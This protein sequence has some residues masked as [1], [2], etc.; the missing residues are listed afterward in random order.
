MPV[1]I[2]DISEGGVRLETAE[3]LECGSFIVVEVEDSTLVG[4]V[5]Y[6]RLE[7][8]GY[9]IGVRVERVLMGES[10]VSHFIESLLTAS[11]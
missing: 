1:L 2:R 6:C 9:T 8:A 7:A 11:Y 4:E 5:K 10:P 3:E